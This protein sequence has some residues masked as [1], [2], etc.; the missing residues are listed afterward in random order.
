MMNDLIPCLLIIYNVTKWAVLPAPPWI[1]LQNS[2]W[3]LG[4][5]FEA[6]KR[7]K[8][9]AGLFKKFFSYKIWCKGRTVSTYNKQFENVKA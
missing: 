2:K 4:H 8:W 1:L 3:A 6:T 7:K 5:R 9:Q